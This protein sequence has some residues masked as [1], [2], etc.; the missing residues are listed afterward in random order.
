MSWLSKGVRKVKKVVRKVTAAQAGI[1]T[2]GTVN[3]KKLGISNKSSQSIYKTSGT[4]AKVGGAL[5]VGY[6]LAP[7]A[8]GAAATTKVGG[9]V[10]WSGSVKMISDFL[11]SGGFNGTASA[12]SDGGPM[13]IQQPSIFPVLL[14][15][16]GVILFTMFVYLIGK[17]KR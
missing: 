5:A 14:I 3:P 17:G 2:A 13:A 1:L 8:G 4:V 9:S 10:G 6:V 15:G 16:G 7:T 11:G 12:S